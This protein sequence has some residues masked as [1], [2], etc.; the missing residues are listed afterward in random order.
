MNKIGLTIGKF[1]PFHKGHEYLV[2]TAISEVDELYIM[3]YETDV[4]DM[5]I[6]KRADL[7]KEI[8]PKVNII[9]ARNAP[10]QYGMDEESVK[11]QTDYIKEKTKGLEVTHF[12]SS[13]EYGEHV[14]VA[15]KCIDRRVDNLREAVP[16]SAGKIRA[17]LEKYK[18]FLNEIVYKA[19]TKE[20]GKANE[21]E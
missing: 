17:D 1:A 5:S 19:H 4:T 6:E 16:I 10:K 3:V 13:E 14:A 18:E 2:N 15:L 8:Y 9:Y 20:W 21:E 11:L 12:Y 7:I